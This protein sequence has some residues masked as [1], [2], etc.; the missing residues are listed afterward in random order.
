VRF[1]TGLAAGRRWRCWLA[2]QG[3]DLDQVVDEDPVSAPDRGSVPAVQACAVPAVASTAVAVFGVAGIAAYVSYWHPYEVV[4]AHAESG[5]TTR[6]E[7][8]TI[9]GLVYASSLVVLYAVRH[10]LAVP[11]SARWLLAMRR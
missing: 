3:P 10:Q 9:D 2:G 7:P 11:A 4:R 8:A 1:G 5:V 6:L